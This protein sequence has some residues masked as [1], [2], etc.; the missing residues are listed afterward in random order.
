VGQ[1]TQLVWKAQSGLDLYGVDLPVDP[2]LAQ[3]DYSQH[4]HN[5]A[6][7]RLRLQT[8][9]PTL[10]GPVDCHTVAVERLRVLF[11]Q[12]ARPA[13]GA[14]V[15]ANRALYEPGTRA[16][17]PG[18]AIF[19]FDPAAT[20]AFLEDLAQTLYDLKDS[21]TENPVLLAAAEPLFANEEEWY[22]HRRK[23]VPAELTKGLAVYAG[24]LWIH[25]P[26]LVDGY[27]SSRQPRALPL[28]AEP[29]ETGGL[30][31]IP[32]DRID[33]FWHAAQAAGFRPR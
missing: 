33:Q 13:V 24:D 9:V 26:F 17:H 1:V 18:L 25:R 30:E 12:G 7:F 11:E 3:T 29:G 19:S 15:Q 23:R 14:R 8:P 10:L 6:M 16:G 4:D 28:L 21:D 27:F 5:G 20:P 2:R 32:H 31:L 22:Y